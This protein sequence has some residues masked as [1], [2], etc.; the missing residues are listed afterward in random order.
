MRRRRQR[1]DEASTREGTPKIT[2]KP[3]EARRVQGPILRHS[4]RRK[5]P[6]QH[7]DFGLLASRTG[8]QS[9][10]EATEFVVL[11]YSCPS[12]GIQVC[13]EGYGKPYSTEECPKLKYCHPGWYVEKRFKTLCSCQGCLNG[14]RARERFFFYLG[15]GGARWAPC[16]LSD[17]LRGRGHPVSG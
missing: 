8:R 6:C 12:Q 11:C 17:P 13:P 15:W 5:Q 10:V 1:S 2:S 9:F 7:L 16:Q 3:P 4:L 14:Q